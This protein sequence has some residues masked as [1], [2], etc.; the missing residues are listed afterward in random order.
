MQKLNTVLREE[1]EEFDKKFVMDLSHKDEE[2]QYW[3]IVQNEAVMKNWLAQHDTRI[4]NA[5]LEEIEGREMPETNPDEYSD[6]YNTALTDLAEI[7]K[8]ALE[9]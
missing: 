3:N 8:L 7:I 2:D 9:K 4:L 1:K 5:L 6:G